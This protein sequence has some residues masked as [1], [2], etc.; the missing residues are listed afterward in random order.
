MI[1]SCA[2]SGTESKSLPREVASLGC[3]DLIGYS[4]VSPVIVLLEI[5]LYLFVD[6]R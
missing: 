1:C 6:A 5:V 2:L 4:R 3:Y